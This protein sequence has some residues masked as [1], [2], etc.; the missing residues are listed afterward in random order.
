MKKKTD[1]KVKERARH[2]PYLVCDI[3]G[4]IGKPT[5]PE[6]ELA[7]SPVQCLGKATC[8]SPQLIVIYFG[9]ISIRERNALFELSKVLKQNTHT[10]K[11]PILA[12]LHSKHRKIIEN[13]DRANVDYLRY[14]G[15]AKLDLGHMRKIISGLGPNDRL[16]RHLGILCPF[17]HYK[18]ID[19]RLEIMTCGAYL[20]RMV[21]GGRRLR[22]TCET[23]NHFHCEYYLN[24]RYKP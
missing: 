6:E 1:E 3:S 11:L 22:E 7:H 15:D 5:F 9:E 23:E 18:Q 21:L 10:Q 13:L 19:A 8:L 4:N 16:K 2:F 17:L 12:L 14:I 20:N 24:P